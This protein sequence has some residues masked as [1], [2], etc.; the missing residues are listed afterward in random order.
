VEC[1]AEE[2]RCTADDTC[3]PLTK[4]CNFRYDCPT[5]SSDEEGCP[6]IYTF[7]ECD[8]LAACFWNTV[9]PSTVNWDLAAVG[10]D[11]GG[12]PPV[13]FRNETQGHFLQVHADSNE[14]GEAQVQSP[15]YRDT[16]TECVFIFYLYLYTETADVALY[17]LMKHIELGMYSEL[18][19]LDT[20]VVDNGFWTKVDIGIGRH[21]D[22]VS[23]HLDLVYQG[24]VFDAAVAVDEVE[25]F[26][27]A[28][29]PPQ[30]TCEAT[31]FH[32]V[33]TKACVYEG[34]VCDYAD[35]CGDSTDEGLADMDCNH[36]YIRTN[37]EDPVTPFGFF[38]QDHPAADFEWVRGNG[39]TTNHGTGPPFD[40]TIFSPSGHYLYIGS[41][42]HETNAKAYLTTPL[43]QPPTAGGCTYRMFYHMHGRA[44]GNLTLYHQ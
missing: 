40:H 16:H 7:E 33:I 32:C 43:L 11:P 15:A 14:A 36:D 27:C 2:H 17:P 13:D 1:T 21:R 23:F 24:Q 42:A 8:S 25:F 30:E 4:V 10:T 5:D 34:V 3:I 37:F 29:L 9:T 22:Q 18:D 31:Q 6:F 44:V 39:S 20:S 35:D 38:N 26:D 41:E 19:R 28:L 12:R